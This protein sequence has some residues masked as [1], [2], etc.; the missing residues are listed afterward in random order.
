M[1]FGKK[2]ITAKQIMLK[3]DNIERRLYGKADRL[4]CDELHNLADDI[5]HAIS[6][7][8]LRNQL[9]EME[10]C[11]SYS[12]IC[13]DHGGMCGDCCAQASSY[14]IHQNTDFIDEL[15]CRCWQDRLPVR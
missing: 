4:F 12:A 5:D 8:Q 13:P 7:G 11:E 14:L 9:C 6:R 1:A 3:L 15:K 2:P 10:G